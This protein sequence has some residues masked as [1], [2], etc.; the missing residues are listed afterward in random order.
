MMN[1]LL[2]QVAQR[3]TSFSCSLGAAMS[4][5]TVPLLSQ[6]PPLPRDEQPLLFACE[7]DHAAVRL[8]RPRFTN[9]VT[10]YPGV[11][12]ARLTL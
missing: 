5:V 12:S 1:S 8:P 7:N 2:D 3:A 10:S 4:K 11:G 9:R 6:L